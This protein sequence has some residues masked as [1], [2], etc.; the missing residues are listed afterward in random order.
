MRGHE[1][2]PAFA[3]RAKWFRIIDTDL[4]Q[5]GSIDVATAN[6]ILSEAGWDMSPRKDENHLFPLVTCRGDRLRPGRD[7]FA[8]AGRLVGTESVA[9]WH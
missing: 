6:T 9:E 5:V 3:F 8:T 7:T 2:K 4:T 1:N